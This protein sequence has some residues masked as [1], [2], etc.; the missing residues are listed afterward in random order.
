MEKLGN[1]DRL[2]QGK[3]TGKVRHDHYLHDERTPEQI[4]KEIDEL[5]AILGNKS[6]RSIT[7]TE[8]VPVEDK[9]NGKMIQVG[10]IGQQ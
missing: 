3:E 4:R 10:Q 8:V 9:G 1:M 7:L 2:Y 5:D 6:I